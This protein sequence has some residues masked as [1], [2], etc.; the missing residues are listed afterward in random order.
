MSQHSNYRKPPEATRFKPGQSGNPGGR[1]KRRP[2][3]RERVEQALDR[4][5]P[6]VI[7]GQRQMLPA[8]DVL[9][10]ALVA[11]LSKKPIDL[12]QV[13]RWLEGDRPPGRALDEPQ[14][15]RQDE[16][17]LRDLIRRAQRGDVPSSGEADDDDAA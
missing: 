12:L 3:L 8:A 2:T 9:A 10:N 7:D 4:E 14:D 1:P 15:A 5:V 16:D 6:A 17:L 11:Y 13:G